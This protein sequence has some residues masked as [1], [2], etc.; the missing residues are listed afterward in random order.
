VREK[1]T[2]ATPIAKLSRKNLSAVDTSQKRTSG[3]SARF[4]LSGNGCINQALG[5]SRS[6]S[7]SFAPERI[8]TRFPV[9]L[10]PTVIGGYGKSQD[11]GI[12][13]NLPD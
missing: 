8:A 6:C 2:S 5:H 13:L 11:S 3:K 10:Q 4:H 7:V 9:Q 12:V 1:A